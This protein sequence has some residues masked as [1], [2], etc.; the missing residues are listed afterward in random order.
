MKSGSKFQSHYLLLYALKSAF[1]V[2]PTLHSS[3]RSRDRGHVPAAPAVQVAL[4]E[5]S[6]QVLEQSRVSNAVE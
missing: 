6:E 2:L 5:A 4:I 3:E 1:L